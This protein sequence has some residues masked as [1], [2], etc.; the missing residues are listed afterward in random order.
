MAGNRANKAVVFDDRV[1]FKRSFEH[2]GDFDNRCTGVY[3]L[4]AIGH[5][6]L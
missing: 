3:G 4:N 6:I 5:K 1:A 2:L